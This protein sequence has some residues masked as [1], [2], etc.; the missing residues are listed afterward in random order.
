MKK[1][2]EKNGGIYFLKIWKKKIKNGKIK[3][4]IFFKNYKYIYTNIIN[5]NN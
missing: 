2:N 5:R 1:K 4:Y 3:N